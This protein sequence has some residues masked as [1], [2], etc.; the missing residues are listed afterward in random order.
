MGEAAF[1]AGNTVGQNE[2]QAPSSIASYIGNEITGS[3]G[4]NAALIRSLTAAAIS[5]ST[6]SGVSGSVVSTGSF[7]LLQVDGANFT[8]A[9]L[10][11][12]IPAA[13][14][15][16]IDGLSDAVSGIA[17]FS[18]SLILGHQTTGTLNNA[19]NHVAVGYGAMDAV[20]SATDNVCI[21]YNAGGAITTASENVAIGSGAF[22]AAVAS[23]SQN[24]A[25]GAGAL[26]NINHSGADRNIAIGYNAGDGMGTLGSADNV[27]I[28]V[29]AG[30]G[31]WETGA[32]AGNVAIGN[33]SMDAVM[34]AC[35]GNTCLG[36]L[37]GTAL[38]TGHSNVYIGKEAGGISDSGT[39]NTCL[40]YASGV[41]NG[42]NHEVVAIGYGATCDEDQIKIG[43]ADSDFVYT[44]NNSATWSTT[45]DE[46][47]KKD[48][49]DCDLGLA[50][51]ND[52]RPVTFKRK[53]Y[54]DWDEELK[55]EP[56][57]TTLPDGSESVL[58]ITKSRIDTEKI[59]YGFI[60]QE[61]KAVM[62]NHSHSEFPAWSI[63]NSKTGE[64][65]VGFGEFV[66]PLIKA[67]Q[68]LSA[69]VEALENE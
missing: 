57:V 8:S 65:G 69:K 17:N 33:Y 4:A 1:I 68:E 63:A 24:V 15:S 50:F 51:V 13:G 21:G 56:R 64:Q 66:I 42:G 28:G 30:G 2:L 32:S 58:E 62:D 67:V 3:L 35:L 12:A 16:D 9:S 60:A 11:R 59:N 61:V 19:S 52:L 53:A 6:H 10:A 54:V 39:R 38:T 47:I 46:R 26:G 36:H 31:A 45:S 44:N 18:N 23:L 29:D 48:I 22:D 27:F 37:S 34:N 25:I 20:T 14:A 49:E 7:G 43:S 41:N 55:E 5:G 40:G